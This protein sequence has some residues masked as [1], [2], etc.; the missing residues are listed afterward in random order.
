MTY[1]SRFDR[2]NLTARFADLLEE[3]LHGA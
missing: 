2:R 1:I 3:T